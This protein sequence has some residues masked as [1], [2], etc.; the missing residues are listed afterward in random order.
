MRPARKLHRRP[1]RPT[2]SGPRPRSMR[3]NSDKCVTRTVNAVRQLIE[4]SS[5]AQGSL[6]RLCASLEG[7]TEGLSSWKTGQPWFSEP[8]ITP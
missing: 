4:A 5:S 1:G 8:T 6:L 7:A 3:L 2:P